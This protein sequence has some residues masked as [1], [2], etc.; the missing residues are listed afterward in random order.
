VKYNLNFSVKGLPGTGGGRSKF[1]GAGTEWRGLLGEKV[2]KGGGGHGVLCHSDE[3]S[4]K[5]KLF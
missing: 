1:F 3:K 2:K 5:Q 4:L